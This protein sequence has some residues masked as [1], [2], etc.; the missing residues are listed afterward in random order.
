MAIFK[1][2]QD[3]KQT[4][5]YRDLFEVEAENEA[6][7]IAKVKEA[8]EQRASDDLEENSDFK[9]NNGK[10]L[11]QTKENM[12]PQDNGGQATVEISVDRNWGI[13]PIFN[14]I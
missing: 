2:V 5:W 11:Y 9:F 1:F 13:R 3:I 8:W 12:T 10:Y 7:A 6:E 4:I 14:N